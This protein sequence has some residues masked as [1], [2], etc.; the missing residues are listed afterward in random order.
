MTEDE[1]KKMI[2]DFRKGRTED[3]ETADDW[4][5]EEIIEAAKR[6]MKRLGL[7][8]ELLQKPKSKRR[9]MS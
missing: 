9:W 8:G 3:E 2:E 6:I 7:E 1:K 4:T 5:D